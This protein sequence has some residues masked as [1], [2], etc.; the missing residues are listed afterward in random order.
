VQADDPWWIE[1]T[2]AT[3]TSFNVQAD[4]A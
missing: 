4:L 2:G 1:V 3:D